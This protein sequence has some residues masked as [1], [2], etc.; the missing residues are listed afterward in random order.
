MYNID[1]ITAY[2]F[3]EYEK[4]LNNP[5]LLEE[6]KEDYKKKYD[7]DSDASRLAFKESLDNYVL[8]K[9]QLDINYG[10]SNQFFNYFNYLKS[11]LNETAVTINDK[12]YYV[13]LSNNVIFSDSRLC[14]LLTLDYKISDIDLKDANNEFSELLSGILDSM[15]E[16]K[17]ITQEELHIMSDYIYTSR[18]HNLA[19]LNGF[20]EY[21]FN[22]L[23][24]NITPDPA[25]IGA[26]INC[27]VAFYYDDERVSKSSRF[28]ICEKDNGK[29]VDKAHTNYENKYGVFSKSFLD[30]LD[31][32]SAQSL[33]CST[34]SKDIYWLMNTT[35][36]E[37]VHQHQLFEANRRSLSSSC[38]A[39]TIKD[40]LRK[41]MPYVYDY[42]NS[43]IKNYNFNSE[44]D[45]TNLEA[46]ERSWD[47][48]QTFISQYVDFE[49]S[50]YNDEEGNKRDKLET[51]RDNTYDVRIKRAFS[52]KSDTFTSIFDKDATDELKT[53]K[54]FN[55]GYDIDNLV[56]VVK[57][58]P[59]VL[60]QYPILQ[61]FFNID[62]TFNPIKTLTASDVFHD[63]IKYRKN[64]YGSELN[65][66]SAYVHFDDIYN[67]IATN[68]ISEEDAKALIA[69]LYD[70]SN[71]IANKFVDFR[72]INLLYNRINDYID[73]E[74][75][76]KAFIN[77]YSMLIDTLLNTKKLYDFIKEKYPSYVI[78]EQSEFYFRTI[79]RGP[80]YVITDSISTD[81]RYCKLLRNPELLNILN[82]A[83]GLNI[84]SI[85]SEVDFLNGL[86][87]E[88]IEDYQPG[89]G[90]G[91]GRK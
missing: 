3:S 23:P 52:M 85:I 4:Y 32:H 5:S 17:P 48:C 41:Y 55:T 16:H 9:F 91:V 64:I 11:I 7:N 58:H 74:L 60:N 84:T 24:D 78:K 29:N 49:H 10:S 71:S 89:E 28:F 63:G 21:V 30:D 38:I 57:R 56:K 27:F 35:F 76:E 12:T 19:F 61:E 88:F 51:A 70:V 86:L 43:I 80:I 47:L 33:S 69:S 54:A 82:K 44:I 53:I 83:S 79:I 1:F 13:E 45:E 77:Y 25:L 2:K 72:N 36:R 50:Y 40:V 66:Y 90:S 46:D 8:Y 20:I 59:E 26:I 39:T 81:E 62:G 22:Y 42:E 6:L 73:E 14:R 37:L 75:I 34:S 67:E 65:I 15:K 87:E 68:G 18:V 31:L